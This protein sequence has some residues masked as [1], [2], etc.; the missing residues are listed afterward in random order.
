MAEPLRRALAPLA[1]PIRAAFV[2]GSVAKGTDKAASDIDLMVISDALRYADLF[3]ALQKAEARLARKV[4]PT[5]MI[6]S[7]MLMLEHLGEVEAAR[8]LERAVARVIAD[9]KH[10][11]YD[12]KADRK[13]PSAVGTR[14]MGQAIIAALGKKMVA[15]T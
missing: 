14:A 10:V 1:K 15:K 11:T 5:A 2:Y 4:N 3:E 9:G 12:L 13:D 7:G 6:L 8:R